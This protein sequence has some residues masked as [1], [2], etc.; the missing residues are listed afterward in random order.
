MLS[1]L[2][3]GALYF[4]VAAGLTL[5]F[6][7]MDVLNF[8][9]GAMFMVGAYAGWQFYTNPTFLFGLTPLAF[10]L[11]TGLMATPLL[12]PVVIN[13]PIPEKWQRGL[14]TALF[15]AAIAVGVIGVSGW[16]FWVWPRRRWSPLWLPPTPWRRRRPRS[17][18]RFFGSGPRSCWWPGCWRRWPRPVPV[19]RRNSSGAGRPG[20]TGLPAARYWR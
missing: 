15:L 5:I 2:T 16:T 12:Q 10:A 18:W 14:R 11:L 7:L 9:H 4:M 19:T 17:H 20:G 3:L 8:A 1:G 6:G 13:W